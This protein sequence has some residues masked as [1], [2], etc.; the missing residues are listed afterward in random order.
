MHF[1]S[2]MSTSSGFLIAYQ[3]FVPETRWIHYCSMQPPTPLYGFFN[4][5]PRGWFPEGVCVCIDN[6]FSYLDRR[7]FFEIFFPRYF[8]YDEVLM[9]MYEWFLLREMYFFDRKRVFWDGKKKFLPF[10]GGEFFSQQPPPPPPQSM[11]IQIRGGRGW[12]LHWKVVYGFFCIELRC[13]PYSFSN[14]KSPISK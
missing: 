9:A 7:F 14:N 10:W 2:C 5:N 4:Q 12:G 6:F 3:V 11:K 1:S 8:L 13:I